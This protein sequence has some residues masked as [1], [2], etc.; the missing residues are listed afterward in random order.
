MPRGKKKTTKP[1]KDTEKELTED[2]EKEQEEIIEPV[3]FQYVGNLTKTTT[4]IGIIEKNVP[5]T[6]SD[7][8]QINHFRNLN[9][10]EELPKSYKIEK[11][12]EVNLDIEY[13]IHVKMPPKKTYSINLEDSSADIIDESKTDGT[14]KEIKDEM[15]EE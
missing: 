12:E 15:V 8:S 2:I 10:F 5:F 14:G 13:D 6:V 3:T 9:T 7:A 1:I 11:K 4:L